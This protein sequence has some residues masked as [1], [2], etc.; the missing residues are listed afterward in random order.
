MRSISVDSPAKLN[1][2]LNVL[3]R[4]PDGYHELL[5]LF[6]R[7]SLKDRIT[8]KKTIKPIF[9][10]KTNHPELRRPHENLIYKAYQVLGRIRSWPGGIQVKLD[11]KIPLAAGLG[12]GSSNAAHFLLAMNR[13][14]GLKLP[15]K[16]L[17]QLGAKLGAD[18]PF[19]LQFI[20]FLRVPIVVFHL[21]S[22]YATVCL[23]STGSNAR[24]EIGR[25]DCSQAT[26]AEKFQITQQQFSKIET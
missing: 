1:L 7:I 26:L 9:S 5:T 20:V 2:H 22:R 19:F 23:L 18:V 6:H 25:Q 17:V 10:L 15:Q 24:I 12:G 16:T 3:G 4:R 14:F 8:I 21:N 11:K 13:L